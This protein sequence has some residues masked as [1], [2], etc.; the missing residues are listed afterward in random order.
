MPDWGT[1]IRLRVE[2]LKL[3]PA[4][5]AEIVE[6]LSQHLNDRYEELLAGGAS[7]E[8]AY[9][10][11]M[12]ELD[13]RRLA[14]ELQPRLRPAPRPVVLG[15]DEPGKPLAGLWRDLCYGA[16]LLRL[17][18]GFA[19][20]AILSLALGI[21]ANTAIFQLLD[22]VRLRTLPVR[23]PQEL[24]NIPV[25]YH[26]NG[27]TGSFSSSNPQLTNAV[28]ERLRDQQQAFLSIGAWSA[29]RLNLSQGG[30]AR[31]ANAL[32]VSGNF[33]ETLG[34]RPV[35]GRLLS[36]ADDHPGCGSS[37]VV[38]SDSFWQREFGGGA[39][40][41]G[42]KI[43][44]EGHPFEV[45]GVTPASFFGVEVGNN[46]DVA[47]PIC[48]EPTVAGERQSALRNPQ[49]WWLAA[50]GRLRPGWTMERASAH[51]AAISPGIFEAT[52]PAEYDPTDR[53]NY[54]GFKLGAL[55]AASGLSELR[56]E[57]ESPLWL[58]MGISGWVLLIAC[59]N[60][61]NLMVAR[62]TARQREMAV[63]LALGASPGRLVRQLLAESLLL[64]VVGALCGAGLAQ[65]LSRLLVSFLSA[66]NSHLFIDLTPDWRVLGFTAGLAILTCLLFG[67][68]PAIQGART[69]PGE[70]MKATGRA[71]TAGRGHFA[72]RRGLVVSQIAL[73]LVLLVGA[74][75]FVRTL[76]NLVTLDAGFQR[77]HILI[78]DIDLSPLRLPAA[79][80]VAYKQELLARTRTIPGVISA[81]SVRVVPVSGNG[82][83]D[84][85]SIPGT[86]V[87]R[88]I[89]DF[90]RVSPGYFRT[91]GTPLLA[92]R[93]FDDRDTAASPRVAIV[94]EKF[95][96]KFL[97]GTNPIGRTF[98]VVQQGGKVDRIYQI[99]GLVR[100][101]KYNDLREEFMPI[102]FV[103]EA[104]DDSPDLEAQFMIR[105]D[106]PLTEIIPAV[107]R[108]MAEMDPA[109]VLNFSVFDTVIRAG[110]LRERLMA[111]LSGFFGFLAAI[112]A[113]I[114]LYGVISYTVV[115]RRNEI[116]IRM[117]LGADRSNI[118]GMIMREAGALLGIG[119]ALGT[120]L[121]LIAGGAASTLLFGLRAS[122]PWTLMLAATS[123]AAVAAGASFL[124]AQRASTLDPMQA[125]REE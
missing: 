57:Y 118:V 102:V 41:L 125:L 63:R 124:P 109:M 52:A 54:L 112:L 101:T 25:V 44:L 55:P 123:L 27:R 67:L 70:A 43:A 89:A 42:Q 9:R 100:D 64:A 48:A 86:T 104:Q 37:G 50:I 46:F 36:P 38:I 111:T 108:T 17:N 114:G 3:E 121:A 82:W 74:L 83:N 8:Q 85:I 22:A 59:A 62:A 77:E 110:L 95:V 105:S 78:N 23:D 76:R 113:M 72:V 69:S 90:N 120:G 49:G 28:W 12:E 71:T 6:E 5:E 81:A 103:A 19:L 117:A 32:W 61:A 87:Q 115:R 58:L 2:G 13:S 35:L 34:V 11:V 92:G 88:K 30:E 68:T 94:T 73:S 1:E 40:V 51:L 79:T 116:G 96:N 65:A 99:V 66:Q 16:R 56:R 45:V 33:F 4:R 31:Y 60:L 26:P 15:Q 18:P 97:A 84:N 119:L 91:V 29:Q 39:S 10:S 7:A 107:K 98:G 14:A 106:A 75:L 53:K 24:A 20:V 47:L 122:D 93:D 80:R 21:G